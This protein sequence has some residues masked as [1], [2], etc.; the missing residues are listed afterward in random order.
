VEPMRFQIIRVRLLMA[1]RSKSQLTMRAEVPYKKSGQPI[2][3]TKPDVISPLIPFITPPSA[4]IR[5]A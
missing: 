5:R 3:K 2:Q 1:F 4:P